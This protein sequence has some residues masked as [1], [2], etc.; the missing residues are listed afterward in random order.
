MRNCLASCQM[1]VVT[2][3]SLP[4]AGAMAAGSTVE[5]FEEDGGNEAL[6]GAEMRSEPASTAEAAAEA[7]RA[8]GAAAARLKEEELK[9]RSLE[10]DTVGAHACIP[11]H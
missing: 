3:A 1:S 4:A 8:A 2:L 5:R 7:A 10:E 6:G 11:G 9:R